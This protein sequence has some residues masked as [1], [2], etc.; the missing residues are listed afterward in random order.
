MDA[1]PSRPLV[2][3]PSPKNT[4]QSADELWGASS[5]LMGM[6]SLTFAEKVRQA[7]QLDAVLE[8]YGTSEDED[9][10]FVQN[11]ADAAGWE[12][13]G[14]WTRAVEKQRGRGRST[15]WWYSTSRASWPVRIAPCCWPTSARP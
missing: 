3:L 4:S 11:A 9:E 15:D 13:A 8:G 5:G 1:S 12:D 10:E 14:R 7:R 2:A 6:R